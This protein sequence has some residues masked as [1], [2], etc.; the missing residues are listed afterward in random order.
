[1]MRLSFMAFLLLVIS[2]CGSMPAQAESNFKGLNIVLAEA[3]IPAPVASPEAVGT[4][5][6]VPSVVQQHDASQSTTTTETPSATMDA[7]SHEAHGDMHS[8]ATTGEHGKEGSS[9]LPQFNPSSWPSQ[10]FWLTIIFGTFYVLSTTWIVPKLSNIVTTRADYI[11]DNLKA[12]EDLSN[13]ANHIKD[14]YEAS[15]KSSQAKAVDTI[16][17]VQET[18]KQKLNQSVASF[19]ERYEAEVA[20]TEAD[21]ERAKSDAMND[22]NKIVATVASNAAEKI[23]GVPADA[24]Q[25]ENVVRLLNDKKAKAA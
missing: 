15:L 7:Q 9:G 2:M 3:T 10:I 25:A 5:A 16:K 1:M 4:D 22:M 23:A 20:K 18:A 13:K 19:R 8:A 12:A 11:A 24:S 6:M 14:E 21:I 17:S